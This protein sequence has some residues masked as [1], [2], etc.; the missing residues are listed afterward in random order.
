[1]EA[2]FVLLAALNAAGY[3][4]LAAFARRWLRHPSVRRVVNRTGGTLVSS[5]RWPSAGGPPDAEPPLIASALPG[6]AGSRGRSA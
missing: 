1:M 5:A 6:P 3:A 2:T 4:M